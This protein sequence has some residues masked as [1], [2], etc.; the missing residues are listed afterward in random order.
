MRERRPPCF[1]RVLFVVALVVGA[2]STA[3]AIEPGATPAA[4]IDLATPDVQ[5]A[6]RSSLYYMVTVPFD[7]MLDITLTPMGGE[8]DLA[9]IHVS[10]S[11]A[12]E[13][14]KE[15][16]AR[17]EIS[18]RVVKGDRFLLRVISPFGRNVSFK[19]RA[20]VTAPSSGGTASST[21]VPRP[22]TDGRTESSAITIP[23]GQVIPV[24][25][26]GRR[27]FRVAIPKGAVLAVSLY[28]LHGD[29]DLTVMLGGGS[30][31]AAT[32]KR[33]GLFSEHVYLPATSSGEALVIVTPSSQNSSVTNVLQY[34]I[35]ARL[36]HAGVT[37]TMADPESG[38]REAVVRAFSDAPMGSGVPGRSSS[39]DAVTGLSGTRTG[40]LRLP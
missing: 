20:V 11:P 36:K 28:P 1:A 33:L 32:S 12:I 15:G 4:A 2:I 24:Q 40:V 3:S 22:G 16:E 27:H 9:V 37:A 30:K 13:S 29:V 34:G 21:F 31:A 19:L 38:D 17:E 7:G 6:V 8:I 10:G 14:R 18:L 35:V 23:I 39:S 26:E 5:G 25:A